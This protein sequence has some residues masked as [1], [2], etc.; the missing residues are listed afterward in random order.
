MRIIGSKN[1]RYWY[2]HD[3]FQ[4]K[5]SIQTDEIASLPWCAME[6]QYASKVQLKKGEVF[7]EILDAVNKKEPRIN[8]GSI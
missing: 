8:R 5:T 6:R 7:A 4:T 3:K 1:T 2:E